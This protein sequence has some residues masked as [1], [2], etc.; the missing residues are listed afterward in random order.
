MTRIQHQRQGMQCKT[1]FSVLGTLKR[2]DGSFNNVCSTAVSI[3]DSSPESKAWGLSRA[4]E[5]FTQATGKQA[6]WTTLQIIE[7]GT[8]TE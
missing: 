5:K 2:S 4:I 7:T 3:H 8:I 1:Y 6:I